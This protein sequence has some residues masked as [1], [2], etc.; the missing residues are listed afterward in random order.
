MAPLAR[1]TPDDSA[2]VVIDVQER[3]LHVVDPSLREPLVANL[4]RWGAARTILELPV[5]L[6]EQYAKGLGHTVPVVR[7]A[8]DGVRTLEKMT[9]SAFE[10]DG[11]VA[12]L[13]TLAPRNLIVTGVETHVC[14][15]QS[16]RSL[17]ARGHT[18]FVVKD[19]VASR[20]RDNYEVGLALAQAAGAIVTST[21]AVLFDLVQRAGTDTFRA[22]S[23]LVR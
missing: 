11:I 13:D 8:F 18:V 6:T 7:E 4:V 17:L 3:L 1:P 19:A 14:V 5:L 2:L 12:R 23:K 21:E 10:D 20:T 16:V 15:F 9:F 22:I